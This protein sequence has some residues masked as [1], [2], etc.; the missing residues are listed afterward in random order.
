M[1]LTRHG[2]RFVR[3]LVLRFRTGHRA[4][5]RARQGSDLCQRS[6]PCL[7]LRLFQCISLSFT[8]LQFDF[9]LA[10]PRA[11]SGQCALA[12][13]DGVGRRRRGCGLRWSEGVFL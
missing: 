5:A 3:F 1:R 12:V 6:E 7:S 11:R 2:F 8:F 9:E 13:G 10:L 4:P